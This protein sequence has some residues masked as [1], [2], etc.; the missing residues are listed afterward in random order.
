MG[1]T[2]RSMPDYSFDADPNTGV[3]VYDSTRCQG[4]SGWLLFGGTKRVIS[5]AG[6]NCA[7]SRSFFIQIPLQNFARYSENKYFFYQLLR[8]F[9]WNGRW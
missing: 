9:D 7:F 3:S 1:S 8:C 4:V 2:K 6:R 5:G